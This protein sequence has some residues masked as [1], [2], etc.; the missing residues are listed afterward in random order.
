MPTRLCWR[1][2]STML[3]ALGRLARAGRALDCEVRLVERAGIGRATLPQQQVESGAVRARCV[4]PMLEYVHGDA[5]DRILER[6]GRYRGR[7]HQR[8]GVRAFEKRLPSA[9]QN[10]SFDV[11]DGGD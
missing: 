4:E 8:S 5:L 6:V 10:P 9:E 11:V 2:S 3:G 7:R 1:T